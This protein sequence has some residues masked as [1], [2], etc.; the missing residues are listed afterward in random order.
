MPEKPQSLFD[1]ASWPYYSRSGQLYTLFPSWRNFREGDQEQKSSVNIFQL[2]ERGVNRT[3][4][5]HWSQQVCFTPRFYKPCTWLHYCILHRLATSH[6]IFAMPHGKPCLLSGGSGHCG[7]VCLVR[8][9]RA[10][11]SSS[12]NSSPVKRHK[13][14]GSFQNTEIWKPNLRKFG[15]IFEEMSKF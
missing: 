5:H 15:L 2:G 6:S 4:D 7:I 13:F 10:T 14:E 8:K 9:G 11:P 1:S 12:G 3:R